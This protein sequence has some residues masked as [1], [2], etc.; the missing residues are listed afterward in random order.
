MKIM[1]RLP[2]EPDLI[3]VS[4]FDDAVGV[5][6]HLDLTVGV[7]NPFYAFVT[8]SA[9]VESTPAANFDGAPVVSEDFEA[10]QAAIDAMLASPPLDKVWAA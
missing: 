3:V 6:S 10:N 5:A 8:L 7:G 2:D 9:A 4:T 1:H